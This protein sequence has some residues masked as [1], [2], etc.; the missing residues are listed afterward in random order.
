MMDKHIHSSPRKVPVPLN[1][2]AKFQVKGQQQKPCADF[3]PQGRLVNHSNLQKP[4]MSQ[5]ELGET[6]KNVTAFFSH[7]LFLTKFDF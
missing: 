5:Q 6:T 2:G 7:F 1:K 3:Q 4:L